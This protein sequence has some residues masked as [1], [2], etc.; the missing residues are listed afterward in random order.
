MR[1]KI[2]KKASKLKT[3]FVTTHI[4]TAAQLEENYSGCKYFIL[5]HN[6]Y[7]VV[8][9]FRNLSDLNEG[10]DDLLN[11]EYLDLF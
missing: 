1:K 5:Y 10:L 4:F 11:N 8:D 3:M 7:K 6:T 9:A 2:E